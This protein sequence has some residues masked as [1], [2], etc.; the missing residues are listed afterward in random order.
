MPAAQTMAESIAFRGM[1]AALRLPFECI[2]WKLPPCMLNKKSRQKTPK[3][4][5]DRTALF[6]VLVR[7]P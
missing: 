5:N 1:Q 4:A 6:L 2:E 7:S 3:Q